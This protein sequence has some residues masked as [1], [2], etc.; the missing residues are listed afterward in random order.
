MGE[1]GWRRSPYGPV[2]RED[3]ALENMPQDPEVLIRSAKAYWD[4]VVEEAYV[5][6]LMGSRVKSTAFCEKIWQMGWIDRYPEA[7]PQLAALKY[8]F[9]EYDIARACTEYWCER[10][11]L[12]AD[13]N[14]LNQ[15][16]RFYLEEI[17]GDWDKALDWCRRRAEQDRRRGDEPV[18]MILLRHYLQIQNFANERRKEEKP[19]DFWMRMYKLYKLNRIWA[20]QV[21]VERWQRVSL[22]REFGHRDGRKASQWEL[23]N[24]RIRANNGNLIVLAQVLAP[25]WE[26]DTE[27]TIA[28]WR[29][30]WEEGC[31][32]IRQEEAS[33]GSDWFEKEKEMAYQWG[34]EQHEKGKVRREGRNLYMMGLARYA[35]K[36]ADGAVDLMRQACDKLS[37][38]AKGWLQR[39]GI[40]F[41]DKS[42]GK[43]YSDLWKWENLS[44]QMYETP[45]QEGLDQFADVLKQG[46]DLF[47]PQPDAAVPLRQAA[48]A[49]MGEV[50]VLDRIMA[51][52]KQDALVLVNQ[53]MTVA[54]QEPKMAAKLR[55]Y[56]LLVRMHYAKEDE[57][58][59]R[60][61]PL[62]FILVD[63]DAP[64]EVRQLG[65]VARKE[66]WNAMYKLCMYYAQNERTEKNP[67]LTAVS[68]HL[69]RC[70]CELYREIYFQIREEETRR[71]VL[72]DW[73][74]ISV[75]MDGG[76]VGV[77]PMRIG[78]YQE[79]PYC[80]SLLAHDEMAEAMGLP[81]DQMVYYLQIAKDHGYDVDQAWRKWINGQWEI[82]T[83]DQLA[84][85]RSQY[86]QEKQM[87]RDWM[88]EI[89]EIIEMDVEEHM[90]YQ[91][92][93]SAEECTS[94]SG[95]R[96]YQ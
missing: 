85:R 23:K 31:A 32:E 49:L 7:A 57:I 74:R 33:F 11:H 12:T 92:L 16:I 29:A 81:E 9:N 66:D 25:D 10:I 54:R 70:V 58:L 59:L 35:L 15:Q 36:D 78:L 86:Q 75:L 95:S 63:Q 67:H 24:S 69:G 20:H 27:E 79:E 60:K 73:L 5:D 30:K 43:P 3:M 39:H 72:L 44:D 64:E 71:G 22:V 83:P 55:W 76:D 8:A 38:E 50:G 14:T 89:E 34:K 19:A 17:H 51:Q 40:D 21:V 62:D 91:A 6:D 87:V 61:E 46:N 94:L 18:G 47:S 80:C 4:Y 52:G 41:L 88:D 93:E 26:W 90:L 2:I 68:Y 28:A 1:N 77:E 96:V 84:Q 48:T 45:S 13:I 56:S 65:E 42:F 53:M 37:S 82:Y